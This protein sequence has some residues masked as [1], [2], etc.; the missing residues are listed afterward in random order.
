[1]IKEVNFFLIRY[2]LAFLLSWRVLFK[3]LG[4]SKRILQR[5]DSQCPQVRQNVKDEIDSTSR[6]GKKLYHINCGV[7]QEFPALREAVRTRY[8]I[9]SRV[10]I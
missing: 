7:K 1:M 9:F 10:L 8:E 5:I 2:R 3:I 6:F 4:R